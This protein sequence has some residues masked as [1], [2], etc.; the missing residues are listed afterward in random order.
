MKKFPVKIQALTRAELERNINRICAIEHDAAALSGGTYR[1]PWSEEQF[2]LELPGKWRYS[3]ILL[4][5][6]TPVGFYIA[7]RKENRNH[8]GC[9]HGHRVAFDRNIKHPNLLYTVYQDIFCQAKADGL[10]WFTGYQNDYHPMMLHWYMRVLKVEIVGTRDQLEI[11]LGEI[12]D[13]LKLD[14]NGHLFNAAGEGGYFI[15]K[16]IL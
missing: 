6:K 8:E 7:S 10:T 9:V 13:G 12:P 5:E 4:Q 15:V 2:R 1:H 11:F 3:R 14:E 16:C